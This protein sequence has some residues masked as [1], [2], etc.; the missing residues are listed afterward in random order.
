M[1]GDLHSEW[2]RLFMR[3]LHASGVEHVVLSPGSRSTPLALA[4]DAT[5]GMHVSTCIDERSAAFFALGQ[6]RVTGRPSVLLC[7]SGSAGA[8][9]FPAVL[10]AERA[11][12]PLIA[13]TADRPW[14]LTQ[15]HEN[16]TVD[17]TKLFGGHVRA[18]FELGEP[19]PAALRAVP[20]IAAQAALRAQFPVPGPVH[21]NARFRKPLEPVASAGDEPWR[22]ELQRCDQRGAP[23][24]FAGRVLPSVDALERVTQ[25]CASARRGLVLVG[26]AWGNAGQ[27]RD[28]SAPALRQALADFLRTSG[29]ACGAEAAS[30]VLHGPE[31]SGLCAGALDAWLVALFESR[32]PDVVLCLGAPPTSAAW[33]R[34]ARAQAPAT[35]IAVA[36]HDIVD[37]S[38]ATTDAVVCDATE[39]LGCLSER[40]A[41]RPRDAAY[42]EHVLALATT[43]DTPL[44]GDALSEPA[45]AHTVVAA[46]PAGATLLI[47]NS[48]VVR[49]VERYGGR[50]NQSLSVLHQRGV[51][52][53][54]GLI[55]GAAG[56][57][58]VVDA[59][60]AV[61]VLL[62]DVSALHDVGSLALAANASAPLLIVVVNNGGGRIFEQLPIA[63]QISAPSLERLFLTPPTEFLAGA[64]AAFQISHARA[65]TAKALSEALRGALHT[66]RASVI[67]VCPTAEATQIVRARDAAQGTRATQGAVPNAGGAP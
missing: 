1:N 53:I 28:K 7:T 21:V 32:P 12:L 19:D 43:A 50:R 39:L 2:A 58:S 33:S 35:V 54:D 13:L 3:A 4:A 20:R 14:E 26:P 63:A 5:E 27:A 48:Q 65:D 57:R 17:Q 6:G 42:R 34:I 40:L 36:P 25:L 18:C 15:A 37:P 59:S 66:P 46:L 9:Y 23:R 67:E 8:H 22:G 45:I 31:L 41:G 44:S 29:F 56:A 55:A 10:E 52:G 64:C 16:Q 62:G 38:A 51:S 11:H 49:D 61:V 47:G 60:R 24:A 30:D